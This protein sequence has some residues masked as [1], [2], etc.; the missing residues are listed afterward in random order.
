MPKSANRRT[1]KRG[2]NRK[3]PFSAPIKMEV[4]LHYEAN[5]KHR[6]QGLPN[7]TSN[8]HRE[9]SGVNLRS[10][11]RR[12]N[13][14]SLGYMGRDQ[15]GTGKDRRVELNDGK[16]KRVTLGGKSYTKVKNGDTYTYI[17]SKGAVIRKVN[18]KKDQRKEDRRK[19]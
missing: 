12:T 2:E 4:A 10:G 8:K 11:E 14:G 9:I 3:T 1:V 16:S 6:G 7:V 13:M 5:A 15:R 18:V 19:N 17:D